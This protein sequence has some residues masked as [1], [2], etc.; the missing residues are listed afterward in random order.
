MSATS[1]GSPTDE[2][3]FGRRSAT[4]RHG[5]DLARLAPAQEVDVD[6]RPRRCWSRAVD[7]HVEA[8]GVERGVDARFR[9]SRVV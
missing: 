6:G 7:E 1:D 5:A 4:A 9:L 3:G 2:P 8:E